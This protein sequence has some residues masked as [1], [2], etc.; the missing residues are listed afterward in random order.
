MKDRILE[1]LDATIRLH[2]GLKEQA[3]QIASAARVLVD[4]FRSGGTVYVL[5]NGGS[6]ADAQHMAGELVGRFLMERPPLPC[7]ALTTDTSVITAIA[8][9]YGAD[10]VFRKQV[11]AF[12]R[13]GDAVVAISTSG[14]SANVLSAA[15]EARGRGAAVVGLTGS[16]GGRLADVCEVVVQSPSSETPRI[17]E[18]HATV[19]HILCDLIERSLFSS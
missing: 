15:E 11:A 7:H 8:N 9:D 5:G 12:V 18:G 13:E 6:A 4:V 17:Q 1:T 2:E 10:E 3:E 14:N 16:A 19:I